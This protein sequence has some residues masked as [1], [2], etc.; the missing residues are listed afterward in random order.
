MNGADVVSKGWNTPQM[1]AE[2][3][4]LYSMKS[5]D[6]EILSSTQV[7]CSRFPCPECCVILVNAGIKTLY[8]MSDH[9]TS[10]NGGLNYLQTHVVVV[11]QLPEEEVWAKN[12]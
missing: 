1:H 4:A 7:Y 10:N 2:L 6:L 5:I 12:I 3:A 8:Y 9:F 11:T